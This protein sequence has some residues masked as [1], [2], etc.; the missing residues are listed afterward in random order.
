MKAEILQLNKISQVANVSLKNYSIKSE[1]TSPIGIMLRSFNMHDYTLPSSVLAVARAG[2]GVNNIPI[3]EYAEKGVCVFNTPGANANAVAELVVAL[4]LD[5]TRNLFAGSIWASQLQNETIAKDVEKGKGAFAGHEIAGKTICILGLGAIGKKVAKLFNAL[6]LKVKGY[7]PFISDATKEELSFAEIIDDPAKCVKDC[8]FI[9]VHI[10]YMDSTKNFINEKLI[11][12]FKKNTILI[13]AARGEL[14]NNN[15]MLAAIDNGIIS[16]YVTDF[17][18]FDLV[19]KE[20]VILIPH[21]GASTEEAEDNCAIMAAEELV[22]Y[23][24]NGNIKNSVNLPNLVKEKTGKHRVC[25]LTKDNADI[26]SSSTI[27]TASRNGFTYAIIDDDNKIDTT[28]L[29]ALNGVIFVREI[30]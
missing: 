13:N 14:V 9:T 7:D 30:R 10:P 8:D 1:S 4:A 27:K 3:T 15:D 19:N 25:V 16:K 22:D 11:K 5:A 28:A 24:E 23:I 2:A 18:M 29:K 26:T 17:P 21:L 12:N 6:G 20:N